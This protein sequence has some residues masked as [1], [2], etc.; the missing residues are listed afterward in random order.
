MNRLDFM[1]R[2][3]HLNRDGRH[4]TILPGTLAWVRLRSTCDDAQDDRARD[5][6]GGSEVETG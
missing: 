5:G 2:I 3:T 1:W 6:V 4:C